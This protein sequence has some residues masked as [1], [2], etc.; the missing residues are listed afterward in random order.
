MEGVEINSFLPQF[1][2]LLNTHSCLATNKQ[3]L[4]KDEIKQIKLFSE[5]VEVWNSLTTPPSDHTIIYL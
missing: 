3:I 2:L 5:D 4:L 1:T